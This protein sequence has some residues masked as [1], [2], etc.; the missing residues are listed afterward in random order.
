MD[1]YLILTPALVYRGR[2][3]LKALKVLLELPGPQV[4]KELPA[5]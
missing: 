2:L 3:V 4:L 5:K 1:Y